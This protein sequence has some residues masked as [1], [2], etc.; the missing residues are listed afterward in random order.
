MAFFF[1]T[2]PSATPSA[3]FYVKVDSGSGPVDDYRIH[4]MSARILSFCTCGKLSVA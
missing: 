1:W 2:C 3:L 4:A